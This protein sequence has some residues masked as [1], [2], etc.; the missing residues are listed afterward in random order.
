VN[1]FDWQAYF[2]HKAQNYAF[3]ASFLYHHTFEIT[4]EV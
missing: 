4:T 2:A 1:T 3:A